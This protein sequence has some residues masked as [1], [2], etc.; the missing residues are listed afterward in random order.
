MLSGGLAQYMYAY[1]A[2]A[3]YKVIIKF[4]NVASLYIC[5]YSCSVITL[6]LATFLN[7]ISSYFTK[8]T[9]WFKGLLAI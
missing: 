5:S 8:V 9:W 6:L 2:I 1:V 4:N 7:N 3:S